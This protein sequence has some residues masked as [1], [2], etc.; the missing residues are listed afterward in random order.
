MHQHLIGPEQSAPEQG[1][2]LFARL[3][4][5]HAPAILAYLRLH[6]SSQE[7][8]DLLL[9]VF[10]ALLE[11]EDLMQRNAETLRGWLRSVAHHKL[12][13]HYRRGARRQTVTLEEVAERLYEDDAH[14]PEQVALQH[15]QHVQ[16]ATILERLSPLQQQVVRLRFVYGLSCTEIARV[17]DKKEG[18]V[19]K[20]LTR[21]L[22]YA[23]TIY[24][25][26][27]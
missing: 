7:A 2:S 10:L 27:K 5:L 17:L 20:L 26:E 19:R 3:Y 18:A 15:E 9:E 1:N 14:S 16:V 22:N 21:A 13:D 8:E 23:R 25:Q 24:T 6:T 4:D 12:V 11:Q